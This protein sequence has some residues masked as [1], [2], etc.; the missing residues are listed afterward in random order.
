M[1]NVKIEHHIISPGIPIS[2]DL[3][4][5]L[6]G[7]LAFGGVVVLTDAPLSLL[8]ATRKQ[9]LKRSRRVQCQ[10]ASTVNRNKINDLTLKLLWMQRVR[11]T[12]V[13]SGKMADVYFGTAEEL[14]RQSAECMTL[15]VTRKVSREKMR[16]ITAGM[17][18]GAKVVICEN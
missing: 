1:T 17:P 14:A 9:W 13:S 15:Y 3:V 16:V 8:S 10:R 18:K 11:F 2:Y 5:L 12:T 6:S 4:K 7:R